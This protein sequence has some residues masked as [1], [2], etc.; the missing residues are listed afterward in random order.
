[1]NNRLLHINVLDHP[2][3]RNKTVFFYTEEEHANYFK[4]LL[5]EQNIPY[6]F[7]VDDEDG[8]FYF[9]ISRSNVRL[10]KKLNFLVF[11]RYR[12]PFINNVLGKYILLSI[13]LIFI[14]LA[15]IGYIKQHY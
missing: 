7:Q 12:K 5:N 6:E 14:I 3:N 1:M 8:K 13:T 2:T 9:G 15:I 10:G 4:A 11:A